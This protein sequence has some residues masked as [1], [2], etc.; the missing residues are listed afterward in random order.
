[1]IHPSP[2]SFF[3]ALLISRVYLPGFGPAQEK[4]DPWRLHFQ[5]VSRRHTFARQLARSAWIRR[6]KPPT[7]LPMKEIKMTT[8]RTNAIPALSTREGRSI[9]RIHRRFPETGGC[10]ST[11]GAILL[12]GATGF[13]GR[14]LLPRLLARSEGRS[15]YLLIRGRDDAEVQRRFLAMTDS[16]CSRW[17]GLDR[18][19]LRPLRGDLTLPWL[20]L[21]REAARELAGRVTRIIH[22]AASVHLNTSLAEARRTNLGGAREIL[23]LAGSC[24]RLERLAWIST[25]FVAGD[26]QGCI[27]EG[28][29]QCGQNF[30]NAYEQSKFEAELMARSAGTHLPVTIFRPSIIVGD[31]R[32][33]YTCNFASIYWPLRLVAEGVL[34]RISGDPQTPLDLV[35]VNYVADAVVELM[36]HRDAIGGCYQLV[37][38][39]SGT[40]SAQELLSRAIWRFHR[41]GEPLC[42][43]SPGAEA[44]ARLGVFFDYLGGH[45]EFDDSAARSALQG[46]GLRCP[47]VTDYLGRLFSFC[48]RTGWGRQNL[49]RSSSNQFHASCSVKGAAVC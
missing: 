32:D 28:E 31:S 10:R 33:G 45:K 47:R 6:H 23:R 34:R 5:Q 29:L 35:P 37:A 18:T 42:F 30:L 9:S 17:P 13:L 4:G 41:G 40:V 2:A 38:G 16:L 46:T 24:P 8:P 7:M 22:S 49:P 26:R 3:P 11:Q 15:I 27:L 36:E 25:A 12:T 39:R 48:E 1:M 43:V 14:E 21:D 20:G 19:R 44:N